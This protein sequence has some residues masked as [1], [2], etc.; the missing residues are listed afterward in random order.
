MVEDL[1]KLMDYSKNLET[2]RYID[3]N[4]GAKFNEMVEELDVNPNYIHRTVKSLK[5][6]SVIEKTGEEYFLT[7]FGKDFFGIAEGLAALDE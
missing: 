6:E 3:R 4:D 7:S 1:L 5:E 2:L